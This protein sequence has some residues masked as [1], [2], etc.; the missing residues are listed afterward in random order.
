MK[1]KGITLIM[2]ECLMAFSLGIDIF[3]RFDV[4]EA[5]S[6]AVSPFRV[7]EVAELIVLFFLLFLFFTESAYLFIKKRK[8]NE[9]K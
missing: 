8:R 2:M 4:S 5:V 6:N 1:I 9:G 3:Q 7:M